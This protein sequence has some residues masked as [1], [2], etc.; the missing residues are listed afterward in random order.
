MLG[1][2]EREEDQDMATTLENERQTQG[3]AEVSQDKFLE[4]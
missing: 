4:G 1:R 3:S 2:E